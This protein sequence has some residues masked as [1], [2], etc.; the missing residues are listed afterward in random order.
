MHHETINDSLTVYGNDN[1]W[2]TEERNEIINCA[3]KI[4][5]WKKKRRSQSSKPRPAKKQKL[6]DASNTS[7]A[8]SVDLT[9]SSGNE[10]ISDQEST[11]SDSNRDGDSFDTMSNSDEESLDD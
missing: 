6:D 9:Q 8:E 3:V 7:F 2:T 1:L 5:L 11:S 4:Y 10:S